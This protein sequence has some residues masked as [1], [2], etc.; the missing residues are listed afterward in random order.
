MN[1]LISLIFNT[2]Y[3]TSIAHDDQINKFIHTS[4][5]GVSRRK[6]V[7]T[8][9]RVRPVSGEQ[10][11][12]TSIKATQSYK[13]A[14]EHVAYALVFSLRLVSISHPPMSRFCLSCSPSAYLYALCSIYTLLNNMEDKGGWKR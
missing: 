1:I 14:V 3:Y 11:V 9:Q 5:P 6:Q 2:R 8:R 4:S 7:L 13:Q 12:C 10:C